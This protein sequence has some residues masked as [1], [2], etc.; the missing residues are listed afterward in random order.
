MVDIVFKW[1]LPV[2]RLRPIGCS[3]SMSTCDH[4]DSTYCMSGLPRQSLHQ[5]LAFGRELLSAY[6]DDFLH[7]WCLL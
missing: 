2:R 3:F 6:E 7:T 4:V 1:Y 5:Y